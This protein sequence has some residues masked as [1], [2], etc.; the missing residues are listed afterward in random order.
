V[1]T[2]LFVASRY[3]IG[4]IGAKGGTRTPTGSTGPALFELLLVNLSLRATQGFLESITGML[5]LELSVPN[6]STVSRRQSGLSVSL[7]LQGCE[8]ARHVVVDATGLK[9]DQGCVRE[10]RALKARPFSPS[11]G[12]SGYPDEEARQVF[13]LLLS[14][15]AA[16]TSGIQDG[17]HQEA[18]R[19]MVRA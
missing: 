16:G 7:R 9:V 1:S 3:V 8:R 13:R 11:P 14:P 6:Y 15:R 5:K 4:S 17:V 12:S 2:R 10:C 18:I 19:V